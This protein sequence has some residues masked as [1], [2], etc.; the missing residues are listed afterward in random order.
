MKTLFLI[1]ILTL[2]HLASASELEV[3]VIPK[4]PLMGESFNIVFKIKTSSSEEPDISFN[5]IGAEVVG[6]QNQGISVRTTFINGRLNTS[7]EINY[8]YELVA[9]RPG[10]VR[11]GDIKVDVEGEVLRHQNMMI[12][13]LKEAKQAAPIQA[14]AVVDKT[15]VFVGQGFTVRYYLYF[16]AGV[17]GSD[18]KEFP[19]LNKFFKRFLQ[20]NSNPERVQHEGEVY[21]RQLVYSARLFADK[22]GKYFIDGITLKVQYQDRNMN[23]PFGSLGF[24]IRLGQLKSKNV[25]SHPIEIEVKRLPAEN[26]PPH[27]TGLVG[28]HEFNLSITKNKFLVNEPVELKF[29]AAGPGNLE[30]YEAP[31]M[32]QDPSFEEFETNGDLKIETDISATKTFNY[33]YLARSKAELPARIIPLAYFNPEN[34]Q[35]VTV[36]LNLGGITISGEGALPV[37]TPPEE[38]N[39]KSSV[40]DKISESTAPKIE[41]KLNLLAPIFDYHATKE[42]TI[43]WIN[44]TLAFLVSLMILWLGKD[45][46]KPKEKLHL[47]VL[48]RRMKKQGLSYSLLHEFFEE[49]SLYFD[50]KSLK[51]MADLMSKI[52]LEAEKKESIQKIIDACEKKEFY[53]KNKGMVQNIDV[54]PFEELVAKL[55]IAKVSSPHEID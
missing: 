21:H 28:K 7:R 9:A 41:K 12:N 18:I 47:N 36:N 6:R 11:I 14:V 24:G 44:T 39:S 15:S 52:G 4:E 26:V 31:K 5:P 50:G 19:K 37:P 38:Q 45:Y 23:D 49:A 16:K 33:T 46:L 27:F 48:V 1:I 54:K 35:Y 25:T 13:V 2:A 43:H 40:L 3:E 10:M 34:E 32:I 29:T 8:S 55:K 22:E 20:E 30:N 51:S 17:T 42:N 53:D